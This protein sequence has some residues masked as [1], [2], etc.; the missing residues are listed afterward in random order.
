MKT[1]VSG[2]LLFTLS[3]RL[4]GSNF[5][6]FNAVITGWPGYLQDKVAAFA[7]HH[8]NAKTAP[9][10]VPCPL[11]PL[12][13]EVTLFCKI[14]SMTPFWNTVVST[15]LSLINVIVI[16]FRCFI[17][18]CCP[19]RIQRTRHRRPVWKPKMSARNERYVY[20]IGYPQVMVY[21]RMFVMVRSLLKATA[22]A[23]THIR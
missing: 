20:R 1:G 16:F 23:Q 6:T 7:G 2:K 3:L 11:F 18:F 19:S 10:A 21:S 15:F 5:T 13:P 4:S 9:P 8:I 22:L 14:V 12:P 17:I